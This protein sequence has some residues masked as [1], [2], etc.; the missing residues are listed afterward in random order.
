MKRIAILI[1]TALLLQGSI[2]AQIPFF[3]T[4]KVEFEKT[5]YVRQMY[6]EL[7]PEWYERIKEHL[8]QTAI[9]YFDFIGDTTKSLYKPGRE[10][11]IDKRSFYEPI[12]DKNT[13]FTDY[14]AG[15]MI[16]QKPVFEE[17]FLVEDSLAKIKWKI[18][19]DT[20]E[21]A[22]FE[23][24]KAIGIL[25]DSIAVFAFYTDQLLIS[26]GPE[27]IHGLPGMILGM[28]VPRLHITWFATKVEVNGVNVNSVVPATKGKKVTNKTMI[29][30]LDKVV[31]RWGDYGRKLMVN[32]VI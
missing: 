22:G 18:T 21:I 17:T 12:A 20:R 10:G 24:R 15:K 27:S 29:E 9:S 23:C 28:G 16:A 25:N 30:S 5:I 4:I 2:H 26:G 1:I 11:I 19:S 8:P 32:F 31:K 7:E 3:H 14:K 6:K 13:V